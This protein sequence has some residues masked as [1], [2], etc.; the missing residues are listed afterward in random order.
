MSW[1]SKKTV[2]VAGLVAGLGAAPTALSHLNPDEFPQSYRQSLYAILGANMGPMSSMIKGE[3]PWDDARFKGFA[4][5]LAMAAQLNYMRG[6]PDGSQ[7]GQTRAK[8]GIWDNK[9]DFEAKLNDLREA[10]A[11]LAEA[12][13]GTDKKAIME[14]FKAT[15]GTCKACHDEYKSKDYL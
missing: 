5:D 3:I 11:A 13:G 15:G 12:A 9:A 7:G 1:F 4:D 14:A 2:L 6:F 10:S 8:P